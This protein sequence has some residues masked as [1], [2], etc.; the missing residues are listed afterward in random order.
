VLADNF[1]VCD[2]YLLG[3]R[4]HRPDRFDTMSATIDPE[5]RT[6]GL[7]A[8]ACQ[9]PRT[10]VWQVHLAD[11]KLIRH[12]DPTQSSGRSSNTVVATPEPCISSSL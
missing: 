2:A 7:A 4:L 9:Q 8:D 3:D 1:T 11:P 6:A 10:A 5:A 12:P